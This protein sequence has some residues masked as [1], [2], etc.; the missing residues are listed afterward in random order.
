VPRAQRQ[1]QRWW[2]TR[3]DPFAEVWPDIQRKL[4]ADPTIE[5]KSIFQGL[6]ILFPGRFP[7]GQLRTLQRRVADWRLETDICVR[8]EDWTLRLV[9]GKIDETEF[10]P[11]LGSELQGQDVAFLLDCIRYRGIPSRNRAVAV[12]ANINR[13]PIPMIC[14]TLKAKRQTVCSDIQKFEEVGASRLV[15]FSRDIV[16]KADRQGYKGALFAILHEPPSLYGI[17]R[18]R[19]EMADLKEV[20]SSKGFSISLANIRQIIRNAGYTKFRV[21]SCNI[22]VPI[23]KR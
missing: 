16:K 7:N 4:E 15:N 19:W 12:L 5:A 9:Q 14:N 6:Q 22:S 11:S 17:N 3:R 21:R 10:Q 20:M 8:I 13:V 1:T 18:T 23:L 2:C